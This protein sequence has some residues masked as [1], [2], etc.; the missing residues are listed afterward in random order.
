MIYTRLFAN[1]QRKTLDL[2]VVLALFLGLPATLPGATAIAAGA[3]DI[4]APDAM[5]MP[6]VTQGL[7]NEAGEPVRLENLKGDPVLI[8]FW[9]T[10]CAPCVAEL[11]ALSRAADRLAQDGVKVLL[12]SIDR[13]GAGKAMPFLQKHAVNG[14]SLGFDPRAKLSREMGVR[15]LPTT[16]LLNAE[17]TKA[18]QFVGPYEWDDSAM[19]A[20]IRDLARRNR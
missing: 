11:P 2:L 18:W 19:L 5:D 8:N 13:G 6:A 10:W 4:V 3:S 7:I 17:Q 12:V 14:V 15:G 9:A 1:L 20:I 16:F